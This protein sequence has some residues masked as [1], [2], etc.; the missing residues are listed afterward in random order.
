MKDGREVMVRFLAASDKEGLIE[1]FSSM[2]EK[3][4]E[5]SMAPYSV[6]DIGRGLAAFRTELLWSLNIRIRLLDGQVST[7]F[8]VHAD[9]EWGNCQFICIRISKMLD[10]GPQ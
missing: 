7:R 10:W 2:S 9:G 8:P 1:L 6:E 4:L 5:W 3:S